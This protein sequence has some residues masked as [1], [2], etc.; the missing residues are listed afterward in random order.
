MNRIRLSLGLLLGLA[1]PALTL[2][3]QTATDSYRTIEDLTDDV[4]EGPANGGW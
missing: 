2:G 3:P 4:A 1:T